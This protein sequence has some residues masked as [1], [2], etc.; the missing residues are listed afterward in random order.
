MSTVIT[1]AAAAVTAIIVGGALALAGAAGAQA[2]NNYPNSRLPGDQTFFVYVQAGE[3]PYYNFVQAAGDSNQ[4]ADFIITDPAG[5][6]QQTCHFNA[7]APN[8]SQ[9]LASG[10]TSVPGIWSI[11]FEDN[12]VIQ[13]NSTFRWN[14]EVEARTAGNVEIPGRTWVER[15]TQYQAD[16]R[17]QSYWIATREGYVYHVD[18]RAY[19]GIGS[20][21]EANGFGLVDAGTC[22]P[23]YKS[24]EGTVGGANGVF[25]DPRYDYSD[26][27]GDAYKIFLDQPAADL[28]ASAPSA[29][30]V[31]WVRPAAVPPAATDLTL[32][33]S[34]PYTRAGNLEFDLAG[35]N[36]GYS[37]Q[38][39]A[40]NNGQYD[41]P[42]DRT[43]PWGSP[44]G[45]IEVPFDGLDGL[46]APLDV[47]EPFA[48]R[49]VVDRVGEMHLV[50]QDVEQ[51]GNAAGY[52]L[53]V[54]GLTP[55]VVAP[56]P[57]VHWDDR[58]LAPRGTQAPLP[59]AD[60]RAGVDTSTLA[61][62]A[63]T[64][65]WT[66]PWGDLRSMENWT[67]YEAQAGDE[68]LIPAACQPGLS[69]DKES[70]LDDT[71]TNGLADVGESITYTFLVSNTGN[72]PIADVTVDDSLVSGV[73]PAPVDLP[74]FGQQLFT[75]APYVVT[76]AD[77][78]AG[79]V[80]N[81]ATA[82]GVD[83]DDNQVVS[84]EDSEFVATPERDPSLSLD[85][86]AT[87]NDTNNNT[88][89]D[90]GETIEYTF[91]VTNT[92]NVTLTDVSVTDDRV[93]GMSAPVT[94]A[95]DASHEF[96][97]DPYTVVQEDLNVGVVHNS[98]I[99]GGS[100]ALGAVTSNTDTAEV[101]TPVPDPHLTLE[102]SGEI[103][104]DVNGD[105]FADVGD[106][107]T[108]T[109]TA[110]NTGTVD[111]TDVAITDPKVGTTTPATANIGA[112][113]DAVFTATYVV[114]Q[115]D[116]DA[117]AV[118]NS[119]TASGLYAPPNED[120]V[121]VDSAPANDVVP[122][123]EQTPS[124]TVE[125]DGALDDTNGNGVAD[126]GE[127]I[128]YSF[129]VTNTGNT[130]LLGVT[131]VDDRVTGILPASADIL[132]G[133]SE[134]FTAA[135]YVVTQAD[136]DAGEVLNS[137]FARGQVP[138]GPE[139]FSPE[140]EDIVEV[141]EPDPSLEL[142]KTA[143]LD[144]AN[145]NGTADAGET[146]TYTFGVQNTGNVTLYDVAVDDEMLAGLLPGPI[147][148]LPPAAITFF[149]ADPYVVTAADVEAGEIVNVATALATDPT[150]EPIESDEDEATVLA[151]VSTPPSGGGLASTGATLG[152]AGAAA[153]GLLG[154]GAL[155]LL[156]RRARGVRA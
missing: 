133:E 64:H 38:I 128:A 20:T 107:V 39:D 60:G 85:K 70:E 142:A 94:L 115:A 12:E 80:P 52:G 109:F 113:T 136:V 49:V 31:D 71:N 152:W 4:A 36:G 89:A 127:T 141:V 44:P 86:I 154:M 122:T 144:D 61:A 27:C 124:L 149:V 41:D 91:V 106:T 123:P 1:R 96:T 68:T 114:T 132:P 150:G 19:N 145:G 126:V 3:L 139:V 156:A 26:E 53:R 10:L 63:G 14:W 155:V 32:T 45:H 28:P 81:T 65:G 43:I 29:A 23:I 74:V 75:S 104:T 40:N 21:I 50:L 35:V 48:A 103:T 33:A 46:A 7:A 25:I 99:A 72:S 120:P 16:A 17:H 6:V 58:D 147:D 151:T 100:S 18:F 83:P 101:L 102:K 92:G 119:A 13:A 117:G 111:L 137:A 59:Y 79:G 105:G 112:N 62:A 130:T 84:P 56:N 30:G 2:T 55:G 69:I 5:T 138:N 95:P 42:V 129:D 125:K 37:I 51:L 121:T 73:T 24:V 22:T 76:Q 77:V 82:T 134:S 54:T 140:D 143:E 97:A 11:R 118:L 78:D 148:F 67:F 146:I 9:C 135:P 57:R 110:T 47:C 90:L 98:A 116:V 131:V 93:T 8:G 15:Y 153:L 34:S 88:V 108:Y 87:L 66:S